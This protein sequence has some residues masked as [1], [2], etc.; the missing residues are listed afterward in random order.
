MSK[1]NEITSTKDLKFDAQNPNS[2][3]QRGDYMLELSMQQTG[4]NRSVVVDKNGVLVA[5]NKA[6]GKILE[7]GLV[8]PED[9]VVVKTRGEKLVVV[10]RE[11]W[12]I[13]K[14][15]QARLYS[16]LDNQAALV[17]IELT[18]DYL[19]QH[20]AQGVDFSTFLYPEEL[21]A[22]FGKRSGAEGEGIDPE[23]EWDGMPEFEHEDKTAFKSITLHFKDQ[24]AIDQFCE[25]TGLDIR[26]KTRFAWYPEIE[27][28]R[29]SDIRYAADA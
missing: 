22:L 3:T 4:V 18:G 24:D 1:R 8:S 15:A 13:Y 6:T 23:A 20:E 10:Q 21:E 29:T 7:Q 16:Y 9:I 25:A 14:D 19:E 26:E 11:D 2:G 12:D 28:E 17:G 27:I 5:G